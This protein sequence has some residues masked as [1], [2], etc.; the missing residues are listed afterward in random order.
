MATMAKNVIAA[1]TNGVTDI[2]HEERLEDLKGDDKLRYD[3]DIKAVNILLL[4]LP[5]DIYTLI[6]HYQ[7][8]KEIW[9]HIKELMEGTKMTK[10]E[11]ES[12]LYDE[13][14]K[15]T[16]EPR[17]SIHSY[18]LRYAKLINDMN[19]IPMSM[20]P[21]QINTKFV[22]HL[23]PEWSRFVTAAKQAKDLHSVTFDQLCTFLKHNEGDAK[24]V[25]EMRQRFP[26]PL[27]LLAN[28]YNPPP[29]Y[30][31][32]QQ[33]PIFQPDTRLAIPTFLPTDDPIASLN[34]AMIFFSSVYRSKF[35]FMNNHLRTSSNP[36]T[37]ATIQ[38]G[39]CTVRKRVKDSEWFKDKIL[40]AQAQEAEVVLD[41]E[42]QDFLA[43]SLEET[44]DC[45]DL[46]LQAT[47]NF[48]AAHIDE[49][50]ANAI[51]M[52]NL[53][54]VGSLN[55][56]TVAPHY[57]SDTLSKVPHYD[58]YHESD[59]LN[60]NIQ[61]LGYNENIIS[62]N[63]SYDELK[64][65]IDV[66]SYTDYMLTIGN[67]ED[68]YVPPLVQKNDMMLSVIEHMK[69]QVE[70]CNKLRAQLKEKFSESQT[71]HNGTSVNT[72]LSKPSTLGTKLYSVTSFPKSKVIPKVV[73]K[74]DLSKS[75]TSHLTTNKIIEKCIKILALGLLKIKTESINAY[76]K[77][78]RAVHRDYLRVTKEHVATLQELL[79]QA[80]ALK[81]LEEDIGHL[82]WLENYA[83]SSSH[84]MPTIVVPPRHILTTTVIPVDVVEIV[85]CSGLIL[86]QV[87]STSAKP[88]TKN[89]WDWLKR[90]S[91][92]S[93]SPNNEATNSPLNSTNVKPNKEVAEFDSDTFINPFAPPDT[94]SAESSSKI[95]EVWE[96]VPRPD[97]AMIISLK[98]IF[99]V[100]LDE[101][102]GML[103][104]EARLVSKG[105]CQEEGIDFEESFA[106]IARI[107][108]IRIFLAYIAHKNMVVFQMDVKKTF[109]NEILK[110]EV[111]AIQPEWF[112]NQ[113]HPNQNFVK[114]VV[115][116]T[117]FTRKEGND[118]ILVKI[119]VDDIIFA[120][121]NPIF[122]DKFAKLMSKP[123][124]MSM[125]GQISFFGLQISQ[126]SK[127]IFINQSKYALEMLKMY[128]LDQYDA[129]D[130]PMVGQS[131]LDEDPNGTPVDPTRYRGIV[132]SL[133]Y[134][135]AS[136]PDLV[137]I[138]CMCAQ[139]QAKPI[140]KH[141]T[142]VKQ[143]FWYLK[144]TIN[145]GLW[146]SKDIDFNLTDFA[147]ANHAGC[148]DSRKSTSGS[149]QFLGEKLVSWSSKK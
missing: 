48:K 23:Q 13:F 122:Y 85:L 144:G 81:P 146:Y 28:T 132:G 53:S 124:K 58:T 51:F 44:D 27:A 20:T 96:F 11:R 107:E 74:N 24:V 73:E 59:M 50:T 102:G 128:S 120:S 87:A 36:R 109:L 31:I 99:K 34:K 2:R 46:Q 116:P 14:D 101:Y 138:V 95:L 33:P 35:P 137:F 84:D 37:Q 76:F 80:R 19:M 10:Q 57:D 70:K 110:E 114:G 136:R 4:G 15:F 113:D 43:D 83:P 1:D 129:V 126:S 131:K 66:I 40:L 148:Q 88:P 72:K 29:S 93:T 89:D 79:E 56:D 45:E 32:V 143:V 134:L 9:D 41:E 118:L 135:T 47:T 147:D 75:V 26:E 3:S 130:I 39:Q 71:N 30:N 139:Y 142:A 18:Y 117:L 104:N 94:S 42:Q 69:S 55:D 100:K 6:N 103:K 149:A 60:S 141:I 8:A 54:P 68:N 77:N 108:A 25:R 82:T 16:S 65:N 61:E 121:T 7:T 86:N 91:L 92:S 145:M 105:Y 123:S 17:E 5:V 78:N 63:E 112:V 115:D 98:W 106:P 12:M 97:K 125:M 111:Y 133:M 52:E 119:Y 21:M 127:G 90:C 62:T 38:N 67:D 140:E 49:T 22:N 64:C